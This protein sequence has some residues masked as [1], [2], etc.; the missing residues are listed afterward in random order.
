MAQEDLVEGLVVERTR[1]RLSVEDHVKP[2]TQ[3]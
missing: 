3:Q 1:D 2:T